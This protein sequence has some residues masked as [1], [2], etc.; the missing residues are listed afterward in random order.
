MPFNVQ[1]DDRSFVRSIVFAP[2]VGLVIG[3]FMFGAHEIVMRVFPNPFFA[4]FIALT[5]G[6]FLTGGLHLDGL[7]DTF[8]G[9]LSGGDKEKILSVMRD[10][11]I[12]TMGAISLILIII[13]KIGAMMSLGEDRV[14][15]ALF[16]APALARMNIAWCAGLSRYP[17]VDKGLGYA[18]VTMSGMREIII[19]TIIGLL[20]AFLLGQRAGLAGGVVLIV[21]ALLVVVYTK[22][23]I[24]GMT[25]DTIGAAIELSEAVFLGVMVVLPVGM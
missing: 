8:D 16:L 2:L 13:F 7:A 9:F 21:F 22:R 6:I 3:G 1:F 20:C 12:G 4:S 5:L 19:A 15:P 14:L 11:R 17:R 25:G 10:S 18:V 24:G 23:V